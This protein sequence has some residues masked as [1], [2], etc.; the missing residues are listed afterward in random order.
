[1]TI[2]LF[3]LAVYVTALCGGL[4][5]RIE[6]A[7]EEVISLQHAISNQ[8]AIH[9]DCVDENDFYNGYLEGGE[10]D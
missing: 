5:W 1:M 10:D 4:L 9:G 2:R 7:K 8:V 6:K 3:L